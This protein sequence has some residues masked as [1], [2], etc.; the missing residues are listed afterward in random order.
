MEQQKRMISITNIVV[1]KGDELFTKLS[2]LSKV[3]PRTTSATNIIEIK[4]ELLHDRKTI[5]HGKGKEVC[6]HRGNG[7]I[8]INIKGLF[9]G[10]K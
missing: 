4:F 6:F 10:A 9:R 5:N 1:D 3:D 7:K 2:T 8:L